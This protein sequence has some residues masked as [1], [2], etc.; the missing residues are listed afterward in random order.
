MEFLSF[1]IFKFYL[2]I[3]VSTGSSLLYALQLAAAT[4]PLQ[5]EGFSWQWLLVLQSKGSKGAQASILAAR[6]LNSCNSQALD[7]AQAQ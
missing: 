6:G 3:F 7:R 1:L 4:L 2:F 5:C